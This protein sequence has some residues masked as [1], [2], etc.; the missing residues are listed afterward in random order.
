M[1]YTFSGEFKLLLIIRRATRGLV[2]AGHPEVFSL[3]CY[4]ENPPLQVYTQTER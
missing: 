1:K 3:L 2:K 4:T